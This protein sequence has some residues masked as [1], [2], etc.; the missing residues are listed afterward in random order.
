MVS[1]E[2][3]ELVIS[4]QGAAADEERVPVLVVA[5]KLRA[6]QRLLFNVATVLVGGGRRGTWRAD[7]MDACS[8]HF[9]ETRAGSLQIVSEVPDPVFLMF[10]VGDLG[11]DAL[12]KTSDALESITERDAKAIAR[13]FPDS[14]HRARI[15][16]SA[17]ALLPDPEAEY[18]VSVGAAGRVVSLAPELRSFITMVARPDLGTIPGEEIRTLTGKLYRIEVETGQRHLG[19][20][21][22][23]RHIRCFFTPDL[24]D[25]VRD[26]VPGSYVEL[27]G[28]VTLNDQGEV[29]EVEDVIDVRPVDVGPLEWKRVVHEGRRF[30]LRQ[31]V[32]I[33]VEFS[34]GVWVHHLAP[35]GIIAYGHSR[36]ESLDAF[37]EEF[38][39]IY[40]SIVQED[41]AK[42]TEDALELKATMQ[43]LIESV[44]A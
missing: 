11:I 4:I 14:G 26:L 35:L 5:D 12:R 7:V 9:R 39:A 6:A 34:D 1:A 27:D 38:A 13:M 37:R 20:A 18:R 32:H 31:A 29:H 40:D 22:S 15:M 33:S 16:N 21:M 36:L 24:E 19:L 41:E 23:N 25:T 3:R 8:L 2:D 44:E 10:D 43:G 17:L 42:L 28:R 30:V